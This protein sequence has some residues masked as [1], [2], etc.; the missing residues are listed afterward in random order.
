MSDLAGGEDDDQAALLQV[1]EEFADG[2]VIGAGGVAGGEGVDGDDEGSQFGDLGEGFIGEETDVGADAAEEGGEDGAVEDARGVVGDDE[3]G[4]GGGDAFEVGIGC[5]PGDVEVGEEAFLEG[6]SGVRGLEGAVGA[7]G[8]LQAEEARGGAGEG[9]GERGWEEAGEK[10]GEVNLHGCL[11]NQARRALYSR[12]RVDGMAWN[13][14]CEPV[15]W[16][17]PRRRTGSAT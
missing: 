4:A 1:I 6:Q 3:G 8:F 16:S 10:R 9:C 11:C 5:A 13:T 2:L 15:R 14:R 17:W 7:S 12:R